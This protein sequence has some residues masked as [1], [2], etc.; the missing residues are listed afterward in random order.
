MVFI[1]SVMMYPKF[2]SKFVAILISFIIHISKT[3]GEEAKL[4]VSLLKFVHLQKKL[5]MTYLKGY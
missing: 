4:M 1:M 2:Y 5:D 3:G